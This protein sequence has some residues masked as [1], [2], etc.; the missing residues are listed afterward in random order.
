MLTL[1]LNQTPPSLDK[2][3]PT[4]PFLE[5]M[6]KQEAELMSELLRSQLHCRAFAGD[7]VLP[8]L[9]RA[10]ESARW[11]QNCTASAVLQPVAKWRRKPEGNPI[12][13]PV[14]PS[15]GSHLQSAEQWKE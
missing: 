4:L 6:D 3:E 11:T 15:A 2:C 10:E 1:P 7:A 14:S 13:L 5:L 12:R 8:P 9:L